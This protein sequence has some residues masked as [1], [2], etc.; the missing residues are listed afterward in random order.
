MANLPINIAKQSVTKTIYYRS[1]LRV[2]RKLKPSS[3][4]IYRQKLFRM[5]M[6]ETKSMYALM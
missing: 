6:F 3:N 1:F 4:N 2:S 5:L